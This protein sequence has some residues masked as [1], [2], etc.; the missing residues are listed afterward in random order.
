MG[1]QL[2]SMI[3]STKHHTYDI[4]MQTAYQCNK[5]DLFQL[6]RTGHGLEMIIGQS[7]LGLLARFVGLPRLP[8]RVLRHSVKIA[9]SHA[10]LRHH[11]VRETLNVADAAAKYCDF[12]AIVV[13]EVYVKCR[14][15]QFMVVV[16]IARQSLG[17]VARP[18]FVDIS[19]HRDT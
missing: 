11:G 9:M 5:R 13:I 15:R 14:Y 4:F 7:K 8:S 18:M 1:G 10:A 19:E 3:F 17:Q 6:G 2:D 16:L 12:Q